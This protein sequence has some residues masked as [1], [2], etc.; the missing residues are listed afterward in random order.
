[1]YRDS[2]HYA[3]GELYKDL[4]SRRWGWGV[5]EGWNTIWNMLIVLIYNIFSGHPALFK[6]FWK[7]VRHTSPSYI[8]L[9]WKSLPHAV[10]GAA[11]P[12][13][14]PQ[15]N[16]IFPLTILLLLPFSCSPQDSVL[17]ISILFFPPTDF[18]LCTDLYIIH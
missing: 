6:Q 17:K 18:F 12:V 5:W 4:A 3:Y 9:C 1:M 7:T 8:F 16:F 14:Y 13:L 11:S 2:L 10:P 15:V